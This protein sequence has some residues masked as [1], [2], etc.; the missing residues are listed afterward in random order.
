MGS[1]YAL[2]KFVHVLG[3][4]FMAIPLFNLIVV[5][6]RAQLAS[7]FNYY[8]DRYMENIIRRGATR[9]FT[10]QTTVLVSGALLLIVGPLGIG[11][12]WGNWVIL[13]KTV[14][15]LAL[16]GLLSYVH[17]GLQP[18]IEALLA[19]VGPETAAP[20]DLAA[21]LRPY[22]S[23]RKR[24]ATLCLFIVIVTIILGLQVY[25]TFTPALTG[26]LIVLAALFAWRASTTLVRFGW[27]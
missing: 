6:E 23:R 9:C 16:M 27:V 3:F 11:A 24:L 1:G 7:A 25:G 2:L 8:A 20:V 13:V 19:D 14:L 21:Q 12:L 18:K 22:R 26:A 10:F 5:N 17:F 4:V 15:L